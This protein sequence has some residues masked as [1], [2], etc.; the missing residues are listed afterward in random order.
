MI[1]RITFSSI[2]EHGEPL[3]I[4]VSSDL[5]KQASSLLP[6]LVQYLGTLPSPADNIVRTVITALSA[7]EGFGP[8]RNGDAF[9]EHHLLRDM[10][11]VHPETKVKVTMPMYRSFELFARPYK[12]HINRPDSPAYGSVL[13]SF[14]NQPMKRV[15]LVVEWD[16]D[17]APDIC[18][19]L[20]R[21]E[22]VPTSM[23]FRCMPTDVCSIC[24]NPAKNRT[25]YCSH[26][27]QEMLQVRND[28]RIVCA[29]NP[30][31]LFFD[32]SAVHDP[33]DR[34]SRAMAI[35][36]IENGP[37]Y[38]V[39]DEP[40]KVASYNG[41]MS[42]QFTALADAAVKVASTGPMILSIDDEPMDK[43][44]V[45]R[46]ETDKTAIDKGAE[47]KAADI[48]KRIQAN[49]ELG[50]EEVEALRLRMKS[51]QAPCM[52]KSALRQIS[53]FPVK[54]AIATASR[55]GI[56]LYPQEVQFIGLYQEMPK[57][58]ERFFDENLVV[59]SAKPESWDMEDVGTRR[60][61]FFYSFSFL[62]RSIPL[63]T[64]CC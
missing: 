11:Y 52:S 24:G 46:H 63:A 4:P 57:L 62:R 43:I 39:I 42:S 7:F 47:D 50:P 5:S 48:I 58:A 12:H 56:D 53:Q 29:I 2:D 22:A 44:A 23:G 21:Y 45:S 14:Y 35:E 26:L 6:D 64:T 34:T 33:A 3:I 8:N 32:I 41:W 38:E 49:V 40:V 15:E 17:K 54:E 13:R 18:E 25:Q 61:C 31:G 59:V 20:E 10:D 1:K 28:G 27:K 19:K 55:M 60:Q 36:A 51:H 37:K 30:T 16:R 9:M